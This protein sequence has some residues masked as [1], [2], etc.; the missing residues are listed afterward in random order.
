M[1]AIGVLVSDWT[2]RRGLISALLIGAAALLLLKLY[3]PGR[4]YWAGRVLAGLVALAYVWYLVEEL[5][6]DGLASLSPRSRGPSAFKAILGLL[7]IGIPS[8]MYALVGRWTFRS[9]GADAADLVTLQREVC[10]AHGADY[11]ACDPSAKV[12]I[13]SSALR[14]ELPLNGLR[15]PPVG[16]TCGWYIWGGTE[17]RYSHDFFKPMHVHHLAEECPEILPYLGLPPGWRFL[18]SPDHEDIWF[19]QSLLEPERGLN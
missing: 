4:F 16:D 8:A 17:L 12:G 3:D 11:F 18:I 10:Q 2:S 5:A 15:H 7:V 13:S 1:L 19:D 14:R 9:P 6:T